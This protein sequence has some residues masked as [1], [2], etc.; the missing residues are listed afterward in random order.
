MAS[1]T[2]EGEIPL[3][4]VRAPI[5]FG[6]VCGWRTR[7]GTVIAV[8][9]VLEERRGGVRIV[10]WRAPPRPSPRGGQGVSIPFT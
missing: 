2:S 10:G 8:G 5:R 9:G 4:A 3:L 6:C 1:F 7:R